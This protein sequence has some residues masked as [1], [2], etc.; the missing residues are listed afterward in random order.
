M[1]GGPVLHFSIQALFRHGFL[2]RNLCKIAV[3]RV[4]ELQKVLN[5]FPGFEEAEF[6]S[7]FCKIG[8]FLIA[9]FRLEI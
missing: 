7:L 5:F 3:R 4:T 2:Q 1:V 9:S 8:I 6:F